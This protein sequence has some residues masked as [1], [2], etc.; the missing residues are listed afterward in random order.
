MQSSIST[1][2]DEGDAAAAGACE[3]PVGWHPAR[4]FQ[5]KRL[6]VAIKGMLD[7]ESCSYSDACSDACNGERWN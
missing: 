2:F 5:D 6:T 4:K 3:W 1:N 7:T